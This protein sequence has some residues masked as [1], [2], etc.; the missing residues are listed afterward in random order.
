MGELIRTKKNSQY[1]IELSLT[2]LDSDGKRVP[3]NLTGATITFYVYDETQ[4]LIFSAPC[5]INDAANG[6]FSF[7]LTSDNSKR[8]GS[9][10][11]SIFATYAN[12]NNIP[13]DEGI[14]K[15]DIP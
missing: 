15:I 4:D 2:E 11:Y 10:R 3:S 6:I 9:Y 7:L 5:T 12:G 13:W 8:P 1:T 14:F